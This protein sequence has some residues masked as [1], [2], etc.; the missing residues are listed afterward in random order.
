ML[1][2]NLKHQI[3]RYI[4]G[5]LNDAEA[6]EITELI[7]NSDEVKNYYNETKNLWDALDLVESIEPRSDYIARFWEAVDKK[8]NKTFT[9]LIKTVNKKFAFVGSLAVFLLIST[10]MI[11]NYFG[12]VES[13]NSGYDLNSE[14]LLNDLD[15]SLS[16]KAPDYLS[17]YGPWEDVEN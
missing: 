10:F 12:I 3:L 4:S 6:K 15:E 16:L 1:N 11:N 17:V 9:H 13:E 7:Q 2:E 8:E 5:D 14:V